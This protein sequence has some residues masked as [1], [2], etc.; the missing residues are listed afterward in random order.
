M[1]FFGASDYR[2]IVNDSINIGDVIVSVFTTF[3]LGMF[4]AVIGTWNMTASYKNIIIAF[5]GAISGFLGIGMAGWIHQK[6]LD[7]HYYE[8][9]ASRI[10]LPETSKGM[11]DTIVIHI[12]QLNRRFNLRCNVSLEDW[13]KLAKEINKRGKYNVRILQETFGGGVGYAIYNKVTEPLK[14]AG[15]LVDDPRN[16]GVAI[17]DH[18]GVNFFSQLEEGDYETLNLVGNNPPSPLA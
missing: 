13:R 16:G 9:E 11:G 8:F 14:N 4:L 10:S 7:F 6:K 17:T 12:P 3:I 5:S 2:K 15:V 1:E 18:I